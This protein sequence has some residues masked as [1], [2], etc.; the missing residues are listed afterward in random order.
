MRSKQAFY[1]GILA[2]CCIFLSAGNGFFQAAEADEL[3]VGYAV[4]LTGRFG[5]EGKETGRGYNLWREQTNKGGGLLVGD[6]RYMIKFVTYDD[7]SNP[8]VNTKMYEKLI[9]RDKVDLILSPWGSGINFAASAVADKYHYPIV[10]S[11]A[12]ATNSLMS[13]TCMARVATVPTFLK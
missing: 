2:L 10:M 7:E 6:K 12:S 1:L 8:S 4:S 13:S 11:S 5:M 3:T 9:T